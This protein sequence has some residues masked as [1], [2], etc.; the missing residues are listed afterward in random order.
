MLRHCLSPWFVKYRRIESFGLH[1]HLS[2]FEKLKPIRT[3]AAGRPFQVF[4][5]DGFT[6]WS[7]LLRLVK[8]IDGNRE[9]FCML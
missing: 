6:E 8:C 9:L 4:M 3:D 5:I 1:F 2:A 7:R